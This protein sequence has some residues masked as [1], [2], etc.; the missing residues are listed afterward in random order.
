VGRGG[1]GPHLRPLSR[2]DIRGKELEEGGKKE[3]KYT[4]LA[5]R[6]IHV[7]SSKR[8]LAARI[9]QGPA[10]PQKRNVREKRRERGGGKVKRGNVLPSEVRVY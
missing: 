6:V 9:E 8:R 10:R 3:S 1:P 4:K 5:T 2:V 7:L